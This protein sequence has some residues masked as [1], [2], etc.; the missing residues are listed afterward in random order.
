MAVV[1]L[2]YL[3]AHPILGTLARSTAV[4][5]STGMLAEN[6]HL[7]YVV[8]RAREY[9]CRGKKAKYYLGANYNL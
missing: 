9:K 2:L 6:D 7:A 8:T 1:H 4:N 3:L 5:T